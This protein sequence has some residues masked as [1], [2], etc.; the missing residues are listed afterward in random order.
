[1]TAPFAFGARGV[2]SLWA[3]LASVVNTFRR[4]AAAAPDAGRVRASEGCG[5]VSMIVACLFPPDPFGP[6]GKR[7][8]VAVCSP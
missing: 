7:P 6:P 4:R 2:L 5:V 1:M 3:V 8:R